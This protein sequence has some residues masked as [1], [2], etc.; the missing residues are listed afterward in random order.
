MAVKINLTDGTGS[1]TADFKQE[2]TPA[3]QGNV[4]NTINAYNEKIKKEY[5]DKNQARADENALQ[6]SIQKIVEL[7]AKDT[8]F[9]SKTKPANTG[10]EDTEEDRLERYLGSFD[11]DKGKTFDEAGLVRKINVIAN[12]LSGNVDGKKDWTADIHGNNVGKEES[13]LNVPIVGITRKI[14]E[15][16]YSATF[17]NDG[18]NRKL[19]IDGLN[20][21]EIT[22][23]NGEQY[24]ND[25]SEITV[26]SEK[27]VAQMVSQSIKEVLGGF[28]SQIAN[29]TAYLLFQEE[30]IPEAYKF[31][32]QNTNDE[33]IKSAPLYVT[34]ED[35]EIGDFKKTPFYYIHDL[36]G[37]RGNIETPDYCINSDNIEKAL[38]DGIVNGNFRIQADS[39]FTK[40]KVLYNSNDS[41][42]YFIKVP[43]KTL[44]LNLHDNSGKAAGIS[45][46]CKLFD[47]EIASG[48]FNFNTDGTSSVNFPQGSIVE[49]TKPTEFNDQLFWSE[50]YTNTETLS[51]DLSK[52]DAHVYN[53]K[54]TFNFEDSGSESKIEYY[55]NN[56]TLN[57]SLKKAGYKP[58][59]ESLFAGTIANNNL[60]VST[61]KI[62]SKVSEDTDEFVLNS[63]IYWENKPVTVRFTYDDT[64]NIKQSVTASMPT[65]A[66]ITQTVD[67][68][69]SPNKV[70][71][72]TF[73]GWKLGNNICTSVPF[74]DD[75]SIDLIAV[76]TGISYKNYYCLNGGSWDSGVTVSKEHTYLTDS[77]SI[78]T[79]LLRPGYTFVGWYTQQNMEEGD[80]VENYVNQNCTYY[81]KWEENTYTINFLLNDH[82]QLLEGANPIFKYSS[83]SVKAS[84]LPIT[85]G[86]AYATGY[87][88]VGW[89]KTSTL[90][91]ASS[92]AN[93]LDSYAEVSVLNISDFGNGKVVSLSA[94]WRA[95]EVSVTLE[96]YYEVE[97]QVGKYD[98]LETSVGSAKVGEIYSGESY[99]A[100][101]GFIE[102]EV[103]PITVQPVG[104]VLKRYF[105]RN[106][107]TVTYKGTTDGGKIVTYN[108]SD[109][110]QELLTV[111]NE[112]FDCWLKVEGTGD[113]VTKTP[114]KNIGAYHFGDFTVEARF[115]QDAP[116]LGRDFTV[117]TEVNTITISAIGSN[118]TLYLNDGT[119]VKE[120]KS[121][122]PVVFDYSNVYPDGVATTK[123]CFIYFAG[124]ESTN[125]N[126]SSLVEIE[127]IYNSTKPV[128]GVDYL[129]N[130]TTSS[131]TK[132]VEG[133]EY[134]IGDSTNYFDLSSSL[135]IGRN[136]TIRIRRKETFSRFASEDTVESFNGKLAAN[137]DTLKQ[138][139]FN[140]VDVS[141]REQGHIE[142]LAAVF[143]GNHGAL[144]YQTGSG[145]AWLNVNRK[146]SGTESTVLYVDKPC[147]VSFR[148][149]ESD[150]Y[151]AS[152]ET[153]NL[154]V[155]IK[156]HTVTFDTSNI[157]SNSYEFGGLVDGSDGFKLVVDSGSQLCKVEDY[158]S[159]VDKWNVTGYSKNVGALGR[160]ASFLKKGDAYYNEA[161]IIDDDITL[162][163]EWKANEF[164]NV[165]YTDKVYLGDTAVDLPTPI[166]GSFK[167]G[168]SVSIN[169]VHDLTTLASDTGTLEK[170]LNVI[171]QDTDKLL[172]LS[173]VLY[174]EGD[175]NYVDTGVELRDNSTT[176]DF[177]YFGPTPDFS[178]Y[179][180]SFPYMFA[181]KFD[182]V[183]SGTANAVIQFQNDTDAG[184]NIGM[185]QSVG[186]YGGNGLE[187]FKFR[188]SGTTLHVYYKDDP[189]ADTYNTL[190]TFQVAS[191]NMDSN[192]NI[193]VIFHSAYINNVFWPKKQITGV[194]AIKPLITNPSDIYTLSVDT[195]GAT[196]IEGKDGWTVTQANTAT[197]E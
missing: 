139:N 191:G 176:Y 105:D 53:K 30:E 124:N 24:E 43:Q 70:V 67:S 79:S 187:N 49:I 99:S 153:V 146:E 186:Y 159:N 22:R 95:K 102:K 4:I 61:D 94:I 173:K 41:S 152:S 2:K 80:K 172:V 16:T 166:S 185:V 178:K 36:N 169:L 64:D 100:N 157:P 42:I 39:E 90:S 120:I 113:N 57:V 60:T 98:L 13:T 137:V 52:N 167:Y 40:L 170:V 54:I 144:Q 93:N 179:P 59:S 168:Q 195:T 158:I 132:Q 182:F 174:K 9:K 130:S 103:S 150:E 116:V 50:N 101:K 84:N 83:M 162:S 142:I 35:K 74:I 192:G 17:I 5:Y 128:S 27:Q 148:Y 69:S 14:E 78:P 114:I 89:A 73:D 56:L 96:Y 88:F 63:K 138:E 11:E 190:D 51:I 45:Y 19:K 21:I 77:E 177:N 125:L 117:R 66:E 131:I 147:T 149:N 26:L 44:T 87:D 29:I 12:I 183:E 181:S 108:Y 38:G 134:R 188:V 115:N 136:D 37:D 194:T 122:S 32:L 71:G 175:L 109:N 140:V 123:S 127:L 164:N 91:V 126:P 104:S 196:V 33:G 28:D 72:K 197:N 7:L 107:F 119:T 154:I 189:R 62:W 47:K 15:N 106:T 151:L 165:I 58:I 1:K 31:V 110:A 129:L 92:E 6:E 118:G 145:N 135:V 86:N 143:E 65:G 25:V 121:D 85:L 184:T 82:N 193:T 155:G 133:L 34:Y 76:Q 161:S 112:L 160:T 48:E 20:S 55:N 18:D 46:K 163:M 68:L 156:K 111:D 171:D 23:P 180:D 3:T 10:S 81:A 141:Y 75:E 8:S 97:G